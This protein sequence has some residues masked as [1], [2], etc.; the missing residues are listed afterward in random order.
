M[1][2]PQWMVVT[3]PTHRASNKLLHLSDCPHQ[4]PGTTTFRAATAKEQRSLRTCTDCARKA[5]A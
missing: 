5:R 2:R 4:V 1:N 3:T